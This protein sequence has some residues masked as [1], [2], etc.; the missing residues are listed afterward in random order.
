MIIDGEILTA[1]KGLKPIKGSVFSKLLLFKKGIIQVEVI[2]CDPLIPVLE[3][4][5]PKL[6]VPSNLAVP[7]SGVEAFIDEPH[8]EGTVCPVVNGECL[9]GAGLAAERADEAGNGSSA[10]GIEVPE[11]LKPAC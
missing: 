10:L 9:G 2:T 8:V 4:A 3:H 7:R 11:G 1:N 5:V 6:Q